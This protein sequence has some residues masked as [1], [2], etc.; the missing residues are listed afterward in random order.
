MKKLIALLLAALMVLSLAACGEKKDEGTK[1]IYEDDL[2]PTTEERPSDEL[3]NFPE[4]AL[5]VL[6]DIW[7]LYGDDEKFPVMGGNPEGGV[8]DGPAVYDEA[9]IEG[10]MNHLVVPETSLDD[11]AEAATM[12]HM[13]NANTF[14]SGAVKLADTVDSKAF[15]DAMHT[16]ITNNQ[17]MCGM[18]ERLVIT[19]VS[20]GY[21]L[22]AFGVNDAMTSF[23]EKLNTA[24][25]QQ[26][27]FYDEAITG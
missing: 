19:A 15:A 11:I 13:M 14:T 6:S 18:P 21:V 26:N 27:T 10:L 24:Y 5:D 23:C 16:A 12:L 25:P 20:D 22:I 9:Y 7:A 4:N 2:P 17:W 3:L 1:P 8:M